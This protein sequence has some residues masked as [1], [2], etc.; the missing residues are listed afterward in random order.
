LPEWESILL[1]GLFTTF[2]TTLGGIKAVIWT[3]VIQFCTVSLGIALMFFTALAQIPGGAS[4]AYRIASEAGR[5][6][7]LNLSTDPSQLTSIWACL[8]GG[9]V[10]C[11]APVTTDQAVL[12]RLFTTKSVKDCRRSVITQALILL[13]L[14]LTLYLVGVALFVFYQLHPGRLAGLTK[15]D[16]MVPFFAVRELPAGISGLVI[17]SI[18][19][20]S[21]AVMSAGINSL[22]TATTIDFYQRVFRPRETPE[23]YARVGRIGTLAWGAAMTVVALF[24]NRL[25]ALALAYNKVSSVVSGPLL[26]I[27]LLAA[28]T[29]RATTLGTLLGAAIG[30]VS[31]LCVGAWTNWSFFYQGPIGVVV[32]WVCGYCLSLATRRPEEE[33]VVGLTVWSRP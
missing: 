24:A 31:V 29:S 16:A 32:T 11:M 19:A 1:V 20:A 30:M 33:R 28:L 7:M 26:G 8:L 6:K 15:I 4:E 21:M 14:T 27:F 2:Y 12:Q 3:D 10:L 13:P 9:F 5:L 17:A 23:H 18:L 25:G 22:T